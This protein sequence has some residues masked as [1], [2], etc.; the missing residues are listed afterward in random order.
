MMANKILESRNFPDRGNGVRQM[1]QIGSVLDSARYGME[2]LCKV[3]TGIIRSVRRAQHFL[4][5]LRQSLERHARAAGRPTQAWRWAD[6]SI[7]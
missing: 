7:G 5:L 1:L 3:M 6:W 4:T 2:G